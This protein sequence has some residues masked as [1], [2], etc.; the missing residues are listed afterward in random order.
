MSVEL[1]FHFCFVLLLFSLSVISG[2]LSPRHGASSGCGWRNGLRIWRVAA[3]TSN[4]QSRTA[5]K[6]WSSSLDVGRGAN[7]ASTSK[8]YHVTKHITKLRT[9][10]DSLVH[11]KQR[12]RDMRF[13][14]WNV[15]SLYS[16]GSLTTA[17]RELARYK[18]D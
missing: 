18:L 15:R 10:T 17:A 4:K 6:G 13:G 8:N 7:N 12:Q 3:S 2:S 1:L 5:D 16:S 11:L 9:W 14:I